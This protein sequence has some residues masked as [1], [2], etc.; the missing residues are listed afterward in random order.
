MK[1]ANTI[2]PVGKCRVFRKNCVF[3]P[4]MFIILSHILRQAL[5]CA[6]IIGCTGNDQPIGLAVRVFTGISL[7]GDEIRT[8][9][10]ERP[11]CESRILVLLSSYGI[12][13]HKF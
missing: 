6:A 8:L 10:L 12:F 13:S 5:G 3:F 11:V 4:R 7:A 1:L 9:F 2:L